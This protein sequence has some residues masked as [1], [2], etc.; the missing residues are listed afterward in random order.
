MNRRSGISKN[1]LQ[2]K[3]SIILC[4]M[5]NQQKYINKKRN[6]KTKNV[7]NQMNQRIQNSVEVNIL[8][9]TKKSIKV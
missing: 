1:H 4:E 7:N 9:Q 2:A 3:K 5:R 8:L 6:L